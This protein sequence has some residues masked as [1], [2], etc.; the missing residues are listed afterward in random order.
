MPLFTKICLDDIQKTVKTADII[1]LFQHRKRESKEETVFVCPFHENPKSELTVNNITQRYSCPSCEANGDAI[2]Y[3]M[4]AKLKTFRQAIQFIAAYYDLKTDEHKV[5]RKPEKD[6]IKDYFK[7][8]SMLDKNT[9][10]TK[11]I[12]AIN[13]YVK[14]TDYDNGTWYR[15]DRLEEFSVEDSESGISIMG[16]TSESEHTLYESCESVAEAERILQEFLSRI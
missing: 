13:G 15:I 1:G 10:K 11:Y 12:P 16:F 5:V 9:K 3:L 8:L 6:K 7:H 14:T 2:S 4:N